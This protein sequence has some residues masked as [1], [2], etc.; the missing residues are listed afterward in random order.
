MTTARTLAL[1]LGLLLVSCTPNGYLPTDPNTTTGDV[2]T[3]TS[4]TTGDET[5]P[6]ELTGRLA[7]GQAAKVRAHA[8]STE[9]PYTVL[10]QSNQ[11]GEI[12]RD[13]TNA[14]GD[15][16]IDLPD[17]EAGNTFVVTILG[18]DGHAVGP[19]VFGASGSDGVTGVRP[20]GDTSL[21]TL[22]LPDDPSAAPIQC[23]TDADT[24]LTNLLDQDVK[25]RLNEHG[26]PVGL[27]SVGKGAAA[28][29]LSGSGNGLADADR[30]GLIDILDADNDGNGVVD[31]FEQHSSDSGVPTDIDFRPYTTVYCAADAASVMYNGTPAQVQQTRIENNNIVFFLN[32]TGT[33]QIA[34]ARILESPAPAYLE[35]M[36]VS[37]NG[38][39]GDQD[40]VPW[41]QSG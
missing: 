15:F 40:L 31:E 28:D 17:N 1:V 9:Y 14:S 23:G 25:A 4:G 6:S 2:T 3:A 7:P 16:A 20:A 38:D 34:S 36:E 26:A 22:N 21:G 19:V 12:Y 27:D 30:D 35:Q 13:E 24:D 41:S 11:T 33:R 29:N 5:S 39:G 8:Q 32:S 10:A 18:P 37:G